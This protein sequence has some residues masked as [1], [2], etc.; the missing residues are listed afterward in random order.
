MITTNLAFMVLGFL[1]I[2]LAVLDVTVTNFVPEGFTDV[3]STLIGYSYAF[4]AIFPVSWFWIIFSSFV[5]FEFTVMLFRGGMWL[6][7]VLRHAIRG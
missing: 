7:D 4:D 2:P 3:L 6:F 1:T 5:A